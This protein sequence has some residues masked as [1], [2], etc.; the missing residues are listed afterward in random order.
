MAH[1]LHKIK[2]TSIPTFR[3]ITAISLPI[4]SYEGVPRHINRRSFHAV[5]SKMPVKTDDSKTLPKEGIQPKTEDKMPADT[6][7][8]SPEENIKVADTKKI[9]QTTTKRA[10]D[11]HWINRYEPAGED[12]FG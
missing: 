11:C 4:A 8:V 5:H 9:N 2:T 12:W 3:A 10:T 6:V 1:L 7:K